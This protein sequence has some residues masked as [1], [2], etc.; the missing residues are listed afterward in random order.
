MKER[1]IFHSPTPIKH[2]KRHEIFSSMLIFVCLPIAN[3]LIVCAGKQSALYNSISRL[4]WPEGLLWLIYFW[5]ILN[6]G[7]F[8]YATELTLRAGGYTKKWNKIIIAIEII[9]A[10]MMTVGVSIPSYPYEEFKYV[11]M[12]TFHTSISSVGFLGFYIVL[13]VLSISMLNRNTRQALLSFGF[14]AFI[15]IVGIFFLVKVNDPTS[16]C[17][18][19]APAQILIFDLYCLQSLLNY[20]GM[21]L[22]SQEKQDDIVHTNG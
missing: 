1:N 5:G 3:C 7:C 2:Q 14:N 8:I 9:V 12:R 6:I 17:H 13:L 19:S 10:L 15:V 16:Y 22:F 4:A 18:V 21:T 20:Y 11:A